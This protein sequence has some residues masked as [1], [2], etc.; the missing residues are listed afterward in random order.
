MASR[1]GYLANSRYHLLNQPY[2]ESVGPSKPR[3][4]IKTISFVVFL[5]FWY[6]QFVR[7]R[8]SMFI[9]TYD[10]YKSNNNFPVEGSSHSTSTNSSQK[11][12]ARPPRQRRQNFDPHGVYIISMY[13][14]YEKIPEVANWFLIN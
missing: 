9:Y 5:F 8:I 1:N 13:V 7:I 6:F 12:V 3:V 4:R 10:I 14:T 2:S 11:I